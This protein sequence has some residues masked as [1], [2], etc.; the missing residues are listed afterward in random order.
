VQQVVAASWALDVINNQS[1]PIDLKIGKGIVATR[2]ISGLRRPLRFPFQFPVEAEVEIG[3]V[4]LRFL[5]G[6]LFRVFK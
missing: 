1:L 2:A 6:I 3:D 5:T 4:C